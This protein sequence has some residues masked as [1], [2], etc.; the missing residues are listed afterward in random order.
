MLVVP[1]SAQS[2]RSAAAVALRF[3]GS[4]A[5][6]GLG[7]VGQTVQ[8]ADGLDELLVGTREGHGQVWPCDGATLLR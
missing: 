1:W 2:G 5:H 4:P 3:E 8:G 7:A 6:P